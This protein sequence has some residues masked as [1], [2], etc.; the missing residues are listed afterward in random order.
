MYLSDAEDDA[1]KINDT[2]HLNNI[3][4][5]K[6]DIAEMEGNTKLAIKEW[7]KV[8]EHGLKTNISHLLTKLLTG[9]FPHTS[10]P[11]IRSMQ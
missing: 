5:K 2:A 11:I 3:T 6:G 8:L 1:I 4:I 7:T 9:W 10:K